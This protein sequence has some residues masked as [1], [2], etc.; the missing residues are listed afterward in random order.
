MDQNIISV[1][2]F[3]DT[4]LLEYQ[5]K[6]VKSMLEAVLNNRRVLD[7]SD[8]GSGKTWTTC[9]LLSNLEIPFGVISTKASKGVWVRTMG[10]FGLKPQFL[11]TYEMIRD[12]DTPYTR[13]VTLNERKPRFEMTLPQNFVLIL[14]EA[15]R[16]KGLGTFNSRLMKRARECGCYAIALS[17]T[18]A[19]TPLE[20]DALGYFLGLHNG[21][22]FYTWAKRHGCGK[23]P[24]RGLVYFGRK[25]HML[26][27]HKAIFPRLGNRMRVSEIS[28]FP[29]NSIQFTPVSIEN[30]PDYDNLLK[31]RERDFME[32]G[33]AS[34][35]HLAALIDYRQAMELEKVPLIVDKAN[36]L[37]EQ[38][39]S[40][41][42]FV[43]FRE[44][45][46]QIRGELG[47]SEINGD[48]PEN[49]RNRH[50]AAFQKDELK[51]L[52]LTAGAGGESISLHDLRG[53]RPRRPLICPMYSAISYKQIIGRS[54][55]SGGKSKTIQSIIYAMHTREENVCF[56]LKEKINRL[57]LLT[58][59]DLANIDP[60][61][62][63]QWKET[64]DN[65]NKTTR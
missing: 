12:R 8:A 32:R 25:D 63:R 9:S 22:G 37:M 13:Y 65:R 21:S 53:E 51:S 59:G 49:E 34:G 42:I 20:M 31:L 61:T 6:H 18:P 19:T 40:V 26:N 54:C 27:I 36:D 17:A 11:T 39:Y 10:L 62:F 38:G 5:K 46:K 16:C 58:D 1:S 33:I 29:E 30:P 45:A 44:T 3:D 60:S 4:H 52:V 23:G 24:F 50:E 64:H 7:A 35:E 56:T 48:V 14:E 15:H 43:N 57:E 55:R 41:P 47:C 2:T 28:D